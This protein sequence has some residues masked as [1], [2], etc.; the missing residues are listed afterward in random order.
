M[1]RRGDEPRSLG[2]VLDGLAGRL[3]RVDLR[4]VDEVRSLWTSA[5]D[6]VLAEHCRVEMVRDGVLVVTVPSGAFAQRVTDE[7]ASILAVYAV[8][9]ARAPRAV[10]AI[11]RDHTEGS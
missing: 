3:R 10:R 1:S 4:T 6:P 8:L 7:E 9:G 11:V 2:E 5:V